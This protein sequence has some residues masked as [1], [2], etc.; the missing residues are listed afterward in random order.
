MRARGTCAFRRAAILFAVAALVIPNGCLSGPAPQ[1]RFFRLEVPDAAARLELPRLRGRLL[2]DSIRGDG[3]TRERQMLYRKA[4][5]PSQVRREA[6][7]HWVDAPP[8]MVQR[9]VVEFLRSANAA[10]VVVIPEMR[11]GADFRLGGRVH[12]FERLDG[13]GS[14]HVTVELGLTLVREESGEPL[15][16]E[17]YRE[18]QEAAGGAIGDSVEAFNQALHRI[19][20]RLVRDLPEER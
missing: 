7:D 11:V 9:A 13:G 6:Y 1:D 15:L 2:V 16:L 3:M 5:D 18:D 20:E 19:L 17:T 10:E 14:P 8:L 12:R 4:D